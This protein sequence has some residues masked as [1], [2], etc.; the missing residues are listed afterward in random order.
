M[1]HEQYT[2]LF[3]DIAK[4]HRWIQHE[5]LPGKEAFFRIVDS[6]D[7]SLMAKVYLEEFLTKQR[8]IQKNTILI[9][10]N[11][12]ATYNGPASQF[13]KKSMSGVF[14]VLQ[15][16]NGNDFDAQEAALGRTEQISEE[17]IAKVEDMLMG[18]PEEGNCN[19]YNFTPDEIGQDKIGPVAN[20]WFGTF[21]YFTLQWQFDLFNKSVATSE[22]IWL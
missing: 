5:E 13:K 10:M 18:D 22:E 2:A 16:C 3:R 21:F 19:E 20:N 8:N 15:K 11:F 6:A 17:I 4:S 14:F 1:K 9:L 7:N 12:S